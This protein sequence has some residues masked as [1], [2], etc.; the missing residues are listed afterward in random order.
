[1]RYDACHCADLITYRQVRSLG[2]KSRTSTVTSAP[3]LVFDVNVI[4]TPV[5]LI[6]KA[7]HRHW[8][9]FVSVISNRNV[10]GG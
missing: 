8:I 4:V 3:A 5:L 10:L 7:Y 9:D 6:A 1:M 2:R